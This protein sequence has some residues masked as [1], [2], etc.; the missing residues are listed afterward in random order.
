MELS[1]NCNGGSTSYLKTAAC[2]RKCVGGGLKPED[3]FMVKCDGTRLAC[4]DPILPPPIGCPG[5]PNPGRRTLLKARNNRR[6]NRQQQKKKSS[7][8]KATPSPS[9]SPKPLKVRRGQT[10][11]CPNKG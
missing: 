7:L 4:M 5:G 8:A 1:A 2:C 11:G 9:P 10:T 6:N 3:S